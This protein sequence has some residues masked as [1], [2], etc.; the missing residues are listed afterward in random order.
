MPYNAQF[1]PIPTL[2]PPPKSA[3]WKDG[4]LDWNIARFEADSRGMPA[5]EHVC[6][7][8]DNSIAHDQGYY[9]KISEDGI[10]IKSRTESGARLAFQTL[11]QIA[12][13]SDE[14]G[15]R[16]VEISDYPDLEVRGFMLD[17]S[18]CKVPTMDE[19][20]RLLDKLALFKYNRLELYT[21]HTYAFSGHEIVWADAS[22]MT[23]SK[24]ARL[25][26]LCDFAGI[27]LVANMNGLG[28]MERWLRYPQYAHLAE[29]KAPFIDPLGTVRKFPTTL[30]PD[31]SALDFMDG[32]YAQFLPNFSSD[33]INIGG[34]EPWE[35]GMGRSKERCKN[36]GKYRVYIDHILGL[37]NLCA[38]RGKKEIYFWADVLMQNA[39]YSK[40]LPEDMIPVLWGYY[41]DHPYE[42]QCSKMR[43]LG[44]TFLVAPGTNTW[45]SFGL[46]WDCALGNIKTACDCAKKYGAKG[47]ILTQWG[48]GG[49][50]QPWC[51]M[52]PPIALAAAQ[53]WSGDIPEDKVCTALDKLVFSDST[54]E[55]SRSL[56]ALG[57]VDPVQ[58][59]RCFHHK[60]FFASGKE[61]ETAAKE[62]T[63]AKFDEME[64]ALDFAMSL[65]ATSKM[66]CR[67]AEICLCEVALAA[68][69]IKWA[70][71]R[72]RGD[73]YVSTTQQQVSLKF[74]VSEFARVWLAR[75]EFG[76][77]TE[78]L[79]RIKKIS[80]E[81]FAV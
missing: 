78:S 75:A 24:Y 76:G 80:P 33:K 3:Q 77:L 46:R 26:K 37:R 70:I 51:A 8:T 31:K 73:F 65:A 6:S 45:N 72:A 1:T 44:R 39:E 54:G 30:Y 36:E 2:L 49:N 38:A 9:L 61:A 56:C 23:K 35:L 14:R 41:L 62:Y 43:E 48:D 68:E 47:M 28:H 66:R 50:H 67:D 64:A 16:M 55:F 7:Q 57:R 34:D 69:M 59:L 53:A 27:E 58:K 22:P 5:G 60:M 11:R 81:I 52:M 4:F 20:S 63:P 29:S 13:Q 19:L 40:L 32:L 71:A 17:I 12:L 18:R 25:Q 21:E 74:I 42:E 10:T 79:D 15:M